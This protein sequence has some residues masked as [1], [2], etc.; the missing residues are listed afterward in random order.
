MLQFDER[1]NSDPTSGAQSRID[2]EAAGRGLAHAPLILLLM[3]VSLDSK[4]LSFLSSSTRATKAKNENNMLS[5][6]G[7]CRW[8]AHGDEDWWWRWKL[9]QDRERRRA[10]RRNKFILGGLC[11]MDR[12]QTAVRHGLHFFLFY[13]FLC[14]SCCVTR[15]IIRFLFVFFFLWTHS[16][17]SYILLLWHN[18]TPI[19]NGCQWRNYGR[20]VNMFFSLFSF[21]LTAQHSA[22]PKCGWN[23]FE[24][25]LNFMGVIFSND[26]GR[27]ARCL[28][29][30]LLASF[31]YYPYTK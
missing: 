15:I 3:Y 5:H 16:L 13:T 17:T 25:V 21:F 14:H 27:L 8:K 7:A 12:R 2:R 30:I 4:I 24:L 11:V 23:I 18:E 19:M 26:S 1:R 10:R 9:R 29:S 28:C 22:G 20:S 6:A 31:I